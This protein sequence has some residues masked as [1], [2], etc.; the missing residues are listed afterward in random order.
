M[1]AKKIIATTQAP[2]AIGPYSQ[3][4]LA[5]GWLYLSGQIALDP[6]TNSIKGD[7]V[8]EQTG[9][10]L[11]NLKAVIRA[12]GGTLDNVVKTTVY[13]KDFNDFATMNQ[14]YSRYFKNDPPARATVEVTR[15]PKEVKVEI[16][17]VARIG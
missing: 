12:A 8:D 1:T 15:L 9:Q 7:T 4:V 6:V 11:D 17:A 5:D 16:D 2:R 10:V 3:A 13:L 14:V